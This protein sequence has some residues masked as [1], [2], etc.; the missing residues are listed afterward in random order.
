MTCIGHLRS[1]FSFGRIGFWLE[2]SAPRAFAWG[3][4]RLWLEKFFSKIFTKFFN[5]LVGSFHRPAPSLGA[6]WLC[7]V[8]FESTRTSRVDQN[9]LRE[10]LWLF[11]TNGRV[12]L[13]LIFQSNFTRSLVKMRPQNHREQVAVIKKFLEEIF[14]LVTYAGYQ[15]WSLYRP[16]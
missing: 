10:I 12:F 14:G 2:V 9:F 7:G 16:F 1:N 11:L 3:A 5:R 4:N 8:T 13:L 15:G 6:D